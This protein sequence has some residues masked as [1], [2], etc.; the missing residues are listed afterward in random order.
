MRKGL[1]QIIT[2]T[3]DIAVSSETSGGL[4]AIRLV[5]EHAYDAVLL[6]VSKPAKNGIAS[7]KQIRKQRPALPVLMPVLMLS[8]HR[9]GR[10]TISALTVGATGYLSK[11]GAPAVLVDAIREVAADRK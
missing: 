3:A 4:G 1:K 11:Q 6:D 10:Y 7:L 5:R 2:D 8:M 9:E